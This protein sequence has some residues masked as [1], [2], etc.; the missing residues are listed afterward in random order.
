MKG[1]EINW[2]NTNLGF[3]FI[4]LFLR[5]LINKNSDVKMD[6]IELMYNVNQSYF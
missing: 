5:Y 2:A 4:A 1:G 3:G 6:E